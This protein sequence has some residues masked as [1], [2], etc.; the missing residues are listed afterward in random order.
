MPVLEIWDASWRVP[1]APMFIIGLVIVGWGFA[2]GAL[3]F[4]GSQKSGLP[5]IHFPQRPTEA[6]EEPEDA[7]ADQ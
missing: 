5:E 3:A 2:A 6:V 1:N 4:T 7:P